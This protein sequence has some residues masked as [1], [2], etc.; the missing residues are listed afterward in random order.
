MSDILRKFGEKIKHLREERNL[1]QEELAK[2]LG[3]HRTY[4]SQ[5]EN[6]KRNIRLVNIGKIALALNVRLKDLFDFEIDRSDA[7]GD[8]KEVKDKSEIFKERIKDLEK[9]NSIL[10]NKIKSMKKH[11]KKQGYTILLED[12]EKGEL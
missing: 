6:G 12:W 8:R 10:K 2:L 11:L 4:I 3:M 1:S 7:S 9:E 5:V